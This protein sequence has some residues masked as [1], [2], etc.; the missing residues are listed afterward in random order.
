MEMS[1]LR[2]LIKESKTAK[3]ELVATTIRMPKELISFIDELAEYLS[4]SKQEVLLKLVEE[5]AAV[6]QDELRLGEVE[7]SQEPCAFYVLNTNK[8]NSLDDHELMLKDMEAA[9]FYDPWKFNINRIKK[10]DVIFLYEN[11]VGIVAYGK[12]TGDTL[13]RDYDSDKNE[14][15]YQ[16]LQDFVKLMNPIS[17]KEIKKILNRNVVFLRT[18]SAMPD[19]QKILDSLI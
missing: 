19:G 9:A 16:L 10:G 6:A 11:G 18:M 2:S 14:C 17:A 13:I 12:G 15:H 7:E 8:G 4:I 5:G 1:S 3:K